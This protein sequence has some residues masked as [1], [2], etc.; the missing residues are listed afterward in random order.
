MRDLFRIIFISAAV[1]L[2]SCSKQSADE[3]YQAGTC[4]DTHFVT[5]AAGNL[6]VLVDT[7]GMWR[8]SCDEPWISFDVAGGVDRQAF[9]I[10]WESN[11]SDILSVKTTRKADILIRL[12][13]SMTADTLRLIQQGFVRKDYPVA[14]SQ[15]SKITLEFV[16]SEPRTVTLICCTADECDPQQL[17]EWAEE[18]ADLVVMGETHIKHE[19]L[20]VIGCDYNGLSAD[21]EYLAF[22]QLI[23]DT[24]N[25][26]PEA[27]SDWI[28]CGPMYHCSMMQVGYPTTPE[29]YYKK[30]F[31][32]DAHAWQNNMYDVVW[33]KKQDY[34]TT[35]K[36][37]DGFSYSA[38]YVYVSASV[39]AKVY[40]VE[41]LALPFDG[42]KH[43]PIRLTL[44]F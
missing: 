17:R 29:S 13:G 44:K 37:E 21:E 43:N 23:S 5:A 19:G 31:R 36:D 8:V 42:M 6:S 3:L 20:N 9:T 28:I 18:H 40:D 25:S 10:L 39:L 32:S 1:V 33:M 14:N 22:T 38:D 7:E 12:D 35:Y 34:V 24:V 30:D 2:S 26:S 4:L 15:D 11:E 41:V 27:G 16:K